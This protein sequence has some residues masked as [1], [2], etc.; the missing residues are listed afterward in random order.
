M[1]V[2]INKFRVK[3]RHYKDFINETIQVWVKSY[4][5]SSGFSKTNILINNERNEFLTIDMWKSKKYADVFFA[6]NI[7][8]LL[9]SSHVPKRYVS[10]KG[11]MVLK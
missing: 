11:Y 6:K 5:K 10:R 4:K 1:Y 7:K 3:P 9:K 2:V 8:D